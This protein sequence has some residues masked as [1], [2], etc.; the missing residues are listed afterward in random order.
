MR[1][2]PTPLPFSRLPFSYSAHPTTLFS[3]L[4]LQLPGHSRHGTSAPGSHPA[5]M[6]RPLLPQLPPPQKGFPDHLAQRDPRCPVS[7][8]LLSHFI[9]SQHFL[10]LELASSFAQLLSA[11][12]DWNFSPWKCK[13]SLFCTP[14]PCPWKALDGQQLGE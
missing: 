14:M 7:P 8:V 12:P 1:P 4:R 10:S 6:L 2:L 3:V 9:P 11:L 5:E 13:L